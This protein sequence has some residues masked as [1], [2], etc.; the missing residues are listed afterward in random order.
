MNERE[1]RF[2]KIQ[3]HAKDHDRALLHAVA[4]VNPNMSMTI[5]HHAPYMLPTSLQKVVCTLISGI[6]TACAGKT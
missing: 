5:K 3:V 6:I 4:C 1:I 2:P